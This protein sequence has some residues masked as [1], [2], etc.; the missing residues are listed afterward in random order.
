MVKNEIK[1][2]NQNKNEIKTEKKM[3]VKTEK[4]ME[5]EKKQSDVRSFGKISGYATRGKIF[6]GKVV[7]DKMS[8]TVVVQWERRHFVPKYQRYE[9]RRTKV[10]AH[11][12]KE[13][14]AKLGDIVTIAETRP[15][16]KTK[17][18]VVVKIQGAE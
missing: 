14:N 2:K 7:S 4:K 18:F 16:S 15:I 17:N 6:T 11:N 12:P 10:K 9:K 3:V 8:R 13:L 1:N 5:T